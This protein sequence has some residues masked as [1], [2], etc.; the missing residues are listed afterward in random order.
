M[1]RTDFDSPPKLPQ[2]SA[3]IAALDAYIKAVVADSNIGPSDD[4]LDFFGQ[5]D[6]FCQGL[7]WFSGMESLLYIQWVVELPTFIPGIPINF[8]NTHRTTNCH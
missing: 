2:E 5:K 7:T 4:T 1:L 8:S 3:G 6:E